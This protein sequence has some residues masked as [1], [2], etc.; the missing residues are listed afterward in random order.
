[1]AELRAIVEYCDR[2]LR[3]NE[4]AD[5]SGAW[6]GLQVE[7]T[8]T[9]ARIGAAV[10]ACETVIARAV[11][12]GITLLLVHHGLFWSGVQPLVGA[13]FRKIKTALD[14]D[15]AIYSA[16]LPLDLHPVVGN[17]VLLAKALGLKGGEPFFMEKGAPIGLKFHVSLPLADLAARLESVLESSPHLAPGGP[18]KTR[19][20]GIVT[21]G[22]G[23][24]V[25]R[26]AAEGVDTF[27]TGEGPH[28]SFTAAEE[29][30]VNL[31]YAGH[32]AT[33]TFGVKALAAHLSKRFRVPWAFIDHPT[34]L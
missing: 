27:I 33:E 14:H 15:M 12:Q 30:G 26:A 17:N 8:G 2:Y 34:G 5:W 13:P 20:I 4:V 23:A 10:D 11:E 21:G 9:V 6:N 1:M 24:E 3:T 29:V 18:L 28:H 16:H 31:F 25:A 22:A 32:Y 7:N 19:C